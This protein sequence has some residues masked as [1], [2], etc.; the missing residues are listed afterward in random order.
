M[1]PKVLPLSLIF[2]TFDLPPKLRTL[3]IFKFHK[4]L[5]CRVC[6]ECVHSVC[7]A[8]TSLVRVSIICALQYQCVA[9]LS[10]KGFP[11]AHCRGG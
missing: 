1:S 8:R 3:I 7:V 10:L 9:G 4:C 11:L 2:E 6:A 5:R